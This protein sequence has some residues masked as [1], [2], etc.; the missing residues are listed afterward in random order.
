MRYERTFRFSASHFNSR[1]AYEIAWRDHPVKSVASPV[2][3]PLEGA[4]YRHL[5]R[6][7]MDWGN[8]K[9]ALTDVHGHNFKIVISF[10]S[11][12]DGGAE[13]EDEGWLIDDAAVEAI[14]MEWS[15]INLSMPPD[16][17]TSR[18]RA[19]TELMAEKL[20]SKIKK[21][22]LGKVPTEIEFVRVYETDDIFAEAQ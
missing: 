2:E 20:L 22:Q 9:F 12:E 6:D 19:T 7:T 10:I 15:G 18:E 17:Y 14:V 13:L 11:L 4:H 16:F 21:R 1:K 5:L 3:D 8:A